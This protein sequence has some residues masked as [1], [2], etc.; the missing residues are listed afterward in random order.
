MKAVND[1]KNDNIKLIVFGSPIQQ[2]T[3][4]IETLSNSKYI[5]NIG[6]LASER[7]YDYFLASDLA[8]FPGR[9][10][11]LWEQAVGV[12]LPGVFLKWDGHQHIDLDGNC[13]FINNPDINEIKETITLLF[14]DK[15]LFLKMK[16]VAMTK[17]LI[18]FSYFEIAKRAIER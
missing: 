1:L 18:S 7:V 17:G 2:L 10:S 8:F 14:Y 16:S 5:R 11:V 6:W 15:N 4:E 3:E 9:H 13:L 12:G